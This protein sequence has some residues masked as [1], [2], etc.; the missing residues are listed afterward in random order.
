MPI[1]SSDPHFPSTDDVKA[2]LLRRKPP[3]DE[4]SLKKRKKLERKLESLPLY[5]PRKRIPHYF[6]YKMLDDLMKIAC[7]VTI[8]NVQV[9]NWKHKVVAQVVRKRFVVA[10]LLLLSND[11]KISRTKHISQQIYSFLNRY[12]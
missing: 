5:Q 6:W 8:D 11:D 4:K 3:S 9:I 1:S 2:T 10:T 12:I 7:E